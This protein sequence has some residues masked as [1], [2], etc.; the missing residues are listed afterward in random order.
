MVH[1]AR[2]TEPGTSALAGSQPLLRR[3]E[4]VQTPTTCQDA[5]L[6]HSW[7]LRYILDPLTAEQPSPRQIEWAERELQRKYHEWRRGVTREHRDYVGKRHRCIYHVYIEVYRQLFEQA[8]NLPP[9]PPK[10]R[11]SAVAR[12]MIYGLPAAP[13]RETLDTET[14]GSATPSASEQA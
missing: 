2:L 6:F 9:A 10:T 14:G 4:P 5:Q 12:Q 8:V 7:C 13:Q 3:P 1:V 11:P